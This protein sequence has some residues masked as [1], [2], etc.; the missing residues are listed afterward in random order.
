MA[1]VYINLHPDYS[2]ATAI[3]GDG[4]VDIRDYIKHVDWLT[5][6][7]LDRVPQIRIHGTLGKLEKAKDEHMERAAVFAQRMTTFGCDVLV[8]NER[9]EKWSQFESRGFSEDE[10]LDI[11]YQLFREAYKE[12]WA[13][14]GI[15]KYGS[16]LTRAKEQGNPDNIAI[17]EEMLA[18]NVELLENCKKEESRRK[19][20]IKDFWEAKRARQQREE[21][22]SEQEAGSG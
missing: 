16:L 22:P 19:K 7:M 2:Y 13:K 4:Y 11:E 3:I 18:E 6:D 8:R 20:A 21:D 1:T 10:M 14:D 15:E 17:V 12:R 9:G 5:W